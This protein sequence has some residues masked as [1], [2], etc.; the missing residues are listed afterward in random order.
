MSSG[1]TAVCALILHKKLY[2]AWAGD[3]QAALAKRGNVV[4]LVNPHRPERNV[5]ITCL[6]IPHE[7]IVN[8]NMFD[9]IAFNPQSCC[10]NTW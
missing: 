8:H 3:S 10:I 7:M 6:S 5:C 9:I 4:Q 1:T 2:V